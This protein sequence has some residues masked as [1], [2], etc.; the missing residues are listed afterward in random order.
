MLASI[1]FCGEYKLMK[2]TYSGA[3]GGGGSDGNSWTKGIS[4][5][6]QEV[7]PFLYSV[8]HLGQYILSFVTPGYLLTEISPKYAN[9]V[10]KYG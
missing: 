3:G 9:E 5:S 4:Q 10:A 6:A 8:L 1:S 7:N 2:L